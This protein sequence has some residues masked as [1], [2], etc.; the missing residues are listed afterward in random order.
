M[1]NSIGKYEI[2][3]LPSKNDGRGSL[4]YIE[5]ERHCPFK[6]QR[7]YYLYEIVE[8]SERGFHAHKSLQQL[9]VP[10]S[11]QFSITLD[12]GYKRE[13]IRL[14]Q[15]NIGLLINGIIW[16]ELSNFTN[17]AVCLVLCS[18]YYDEEDYIRDYSA[19]LNAVQN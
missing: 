16:R 14:S 2:I 19:F 5:A 11:G 13:T 1:D 15:P 12:T 10:M 3:T 17:N 9:I 7:V 6:I 18:S 8:N 4:T